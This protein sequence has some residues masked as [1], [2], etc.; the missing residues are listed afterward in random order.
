MKSTQRS[1]IGGIHLWPWL[2]CE[3]PSHHQYETAGCRRPEGGR[4]REKAG[5]WGRDGWRDERTVALPSVCVFWPTALLSGPVLK[6]GGVTH[7]LIAT[8]ECLCVFLCV[9]SNSPCTQKLEDHEAPLGKIF[10][11]NLSC[12]I[13]L[14]HGVELQQTRVLY[15][16]YHALHSSHLPL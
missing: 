11:E 5:G 6:L 14:N 8:R 3:G 2:E 15:P 13:S 4:G 7:H 10:M 12:L 1:V 9:G 16:H